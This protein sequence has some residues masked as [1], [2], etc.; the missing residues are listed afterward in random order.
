MRKYT[1][2]KGHWLTWD[3]TKVC[4]KARNEIWAQGLFQWSRLQWE[5]VAFQREKKPKVRKIPWKTEFSTFQ[6]ENET[7]EYIMIGCQ[8]LCLLLGL[9]L[10]IRLIST[11]TCIHTFTQKHI[12]DKNWVKFPMLLLCWPLASS[13]IFNLFSEHNSDIQQLGI[14]KQYKSLFLENRNKVST[15]QIT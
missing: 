12:L 2:Q 4:S 7:M 5:F 13:N 3:H 8:N 1:Y 9:T 15:F 14:N 11:D 6:K 10:T